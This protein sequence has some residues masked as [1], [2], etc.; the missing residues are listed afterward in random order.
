MLIG[1]RVNDRYKLL[2]MVGGGGMAN[3]YLARDMILDRDVAL[4]ILRMDFNNDDEFIKRFNRE[5]QSA[6]SLAHSN[7]VSI[8][9]VG[10][11]GD[12]YYIVM[13]YVEGMTLKQY[14][15]K[16]D[17]IPIK[18]ALDIMKQITAAISHAHQ[19]GIIHRDIKPQNILIDLEGN[20]KITDFGIAIALSSTNITQTN[21]VLGSVH[22]LSPEQA[23]GGMAN[24][25]SDIY[26]LG[27]VMFELFTGRLPFYGESAISIALKHLQSET[28]SPKRWNPD[29]PQS[30]ENI[31]LKATAKDSFYRYESVD[32]MSED[33]RTA[34][35]P[36]RINEAPFVIP[37]DQDA[38]KAI[39][40]ITN[41]QL[42]S[43]D[44]T[45]IREPEKHTLVYDNDKLENTNSKEKNKKQD[46][47]NDNQKRKKGPIILVTSFILLLLL[48]FLAIFLYPSL[49][50]TKEV[51]IPELR[52]E[53][54][55]DA[56]TELLNQ[57]LV[58]GKTIKIEDDTI[59]L[60]AVIKTNPKAGKKVKEGATIDIYQSSGKNKINLSNYVGEKITDVEP[61][62]E[63]MKF[64]DIVVTEEFSDEVAS[65]IILSQ[66][67]IANA[68]VSPEETVIEL[69]V[70]KGSNH[71]ML[72][73]LT[74]YSEAGLKDYASENGLKIEIE[75]EE[76]HNTIS[77]GKVIKQSPLAHSKVEKGTT[78]KVVLSKGK[79]PP[80]KTIK[81]EIVIEYKPKEKGNAQ[82]IQIF[83]EDLSNNMNQPVETFYITETIKRTLEFTVTK[84]QPARYKIM[85][86]KEVIFDEEVRYSE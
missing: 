13:E 24:K 8:Y 57:G 49:F 9:D 83:V 25:K 14:I 33:I 62:L 48:V 6:T 66:D 42:Q 78:V 64:K 15:Q 50:G 44:E 68:E 58:V 34:L 74:G 36:E 20:I 77:V 85:R 1:K 43:T 82:Y 32:A 67:P 47:P 27:I 45:I 39:P 38:T 63:E 11:D 51:T 17:P 29:I 5:A 86:D 19:N 73:D 18:T 70:S 10:E 4:K 35:D 7:I 30:V 31:I 59:P 75:K 80:P 71:I 16:N 26:S 55:D 72:K 46:K 3:V 79:E 81:K 53:A 23:R 52:G 21:A 28:P 65:G 2:K 60:D 37:E 84:D 69:R 54:L 61:L 40:V 56:I 41:E 22:Y 12:I 76:Y